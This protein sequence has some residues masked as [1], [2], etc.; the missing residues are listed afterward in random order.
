D[1]EG[2]APGALYFYNVTND[3]LIQAANGDNLTLDGT[4]TTSLPAWTNSGYIQIS[5][6]G[7]LTLQAAGTPA[8]SSNS[9]WVN[10][11]IISETASTV[12]LGGTFTLGSLGTLVRT[13]GPN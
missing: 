10:I 8:S 7:N 12:N 5:G 4:S 1:A 11:G 2:A 6:S 3:N 13:G 9:T